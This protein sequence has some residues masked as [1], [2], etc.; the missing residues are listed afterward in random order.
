MLVGFQKVLVAGEP[1]LR[2]DHRQHAHHDAERHAVLVHG[3]IFHAADAGNDGRVELRHG[4]RV[5]QLFL[6][7]AVDPSHAGRRTDGAERAAGMRPLVIIHN[8]RP[9]AD[10]RFVGDQQRLEEFVALQPFLA[11]SRQDAADHGRAGMGAGHVVA[12]VD[13]VGVGGMTHRGRRSQDAERLIRAHDGDIPCREHSLRQ[14]QPGLELSAA[15][16]D[17]QSA[18]QIQKAA[19]HAHLHLFGN[20]FPSGV[21]NKVFQSVVCFVMHGITLLV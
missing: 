13:I 20:V 5:V 19:L 4:K 2:L 14:L 3:R 18:R 17:D 21:E 8:G 10:R 12:V 15:G 11:R 1:A 7:K 9:A 16:S 6:R